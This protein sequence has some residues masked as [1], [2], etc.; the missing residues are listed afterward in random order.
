MTPEQSES[1]RLKFMTDV[2]QFKNRNHQGLV[3]ILKAHLMI[4]Q[5]M[6]EIINCN[7]NWN[8]KQLDSARF[9]FAQKIKITIATECLDNSVEK[10]LATLNKIRNSCAHD[11]NF[12]VNEEHWEAI[13]SP[14]IN[15]MPYKS[16]IGSTDDSKWTKWAIWM[17]GIL[18]PTADVYAEETS[19]ISPK[20]T[21]I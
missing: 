5:M 18:F 3:A 4:E 1:N 16:S 20:N 2:I 9:T 21:E 8:N 10:S 12:E 14:F 13:F 15:D 7:F 19:Y 17:L 11:F 6:N